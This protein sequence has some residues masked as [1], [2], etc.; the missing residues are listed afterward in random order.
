MTRPGT[1]FEPAVEPRT[2][3]IPRVDVTPSAPPSGRHSVDGAHWDEAGTVPLRMSELG[4]A[5][6]PGGRRRRPEPGSR[7]ASLDGLRGIAA[8]VVVVYHV[9]LTQ[10]ALAAPYL[11]PGA[12]VGPGTWWATFTPLHLLWAGPEAV[13]VFFVLSGLVLALPVAD[14]GR[15]NL[16]DYYPRR[17]VRLYLPVWGAVGLAVLWAAA[18]PRAWQDGDSWWLAVNTTDPTVG[19]VLAD[20]LLVWSPG[21]AN[22]VLWSL[23]WEVVYCLVLPLVLVAARWGPRLWAVKLLAVV[24]ALVLG[25]VV[26]SLALSSLALFVLGTLMAVEHRRLAAWAARLDGVRYAWPALLVACA[27][28]LLSYWTVHALPLPAAATGPAEDAARALQGLGAGL[29]VFVVWWWAG[30]RRAMTTAVTQWLGSRSFSLYL[31]HLPIAAS[32]AVALG[33][34]PSLAAALG[35]TLLVALPVT[36]VFYRLVERPSHRIARRAGRAVADRTRSAP[37]PE[38]APA[39]AETGPIRRVDARVARPVRPGAGARARRAIDEP[40]RGPAAP[41]NLFVPL[42]QDVPARGSL[43]VPPGPR[44]PEQAYRPAVVP[45]QTASRP[46]AREGAAA[47]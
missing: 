29:T 17:L 14:S 4:V 16:W 39:V 40:R 9:F 27:G 7:I 3:A 22:H 8:L 42:E 43:F 45:R 28:L 26:E 32:V 10:P 46:A 6:R 18:F 5:M 1:L 30:A 38:V 19:K 25:A 44:L 15:L 21:Q 33:G 34:Q 24:G 36:E 47:V 11:D 31:V 41:G 2:T 37:A 12:E 13:F 35:L 20:L 23:Q